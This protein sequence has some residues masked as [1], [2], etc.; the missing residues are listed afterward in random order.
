MFGS[1]NLHEFLTLSI[2]L[3]VVSLAFTILLSVTTTD[4]DD[5]YY[6]IPP[7]SSERLFNL[8]YFSVSTATTVGYGDISPKSMK[9]RFLCI[10]FKLLIFAGAISFLFNF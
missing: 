2:G 3:V 10:V 8:F 1:K 4:D 9:S 5:F 6:V 7:K